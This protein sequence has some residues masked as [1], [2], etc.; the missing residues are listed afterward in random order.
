MS[1]YRFISSR[2]DKV[3]GI[4]A[5]GKSFAGS[6]QLVYGPYTARNS[7]QHQLD[8]QTPGKAKYNQHTGFTSLA[9][10]GIS[11]QGQLALQALA[12]LQ[13]AKR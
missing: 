8:P 6:G 9:G 2:A 4:G 7:V 11:L 1:F 3:F 12:D 5:E 13:G 10:N